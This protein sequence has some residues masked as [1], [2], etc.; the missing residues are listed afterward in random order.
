MDNRRR[1]R[2]TRE[3]VAYKE[4]RGSETGLSVAVRLGETDFAIISQAQ[5]KAN[6][7]VCGC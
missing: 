4:G 1:S 5:S 3:S 7:L 2:K 6:F